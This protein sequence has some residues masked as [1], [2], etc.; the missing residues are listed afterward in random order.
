MNRET[1]G[2]ILRD[3]GKALLIGV[4]VA[5]SYLAGDLLG[6]EAYGVLAAV[7]TF[8][9]LAYAAGSSMIDTAP[10]ADDVET[11]NTETGTDE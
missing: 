2:L 10:G 8:G 11:V 7:L 9:I 6:G 4:A 3:G 5:L 1:L